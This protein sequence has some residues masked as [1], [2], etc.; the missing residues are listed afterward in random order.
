[1]QMS[2]QKHLTLFLFVLLGAVFLPPLLAVAQN[3]PPAETQ[4]AP[5]TDQTQQALPATET[6]QSDVQQNGRQVTEQTDPATG[7]AA[8]SLKEFKPTDK[9]GADSAVSFPVDI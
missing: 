9:I 7:T 2:K 8:R 3:D 6:G 5:V 4:P 1:M